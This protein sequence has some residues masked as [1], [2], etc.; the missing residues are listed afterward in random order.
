LLATL[1]AALAGT[2][3]GIALLLLAGLLP[4]ALLLTG[5]LIALLLLVLV[6]VGILVLAH[7]ISFQRWSVML[8][9]RTPNKRGANA[10]GS[11]QA[12]YDPAG[13]GWRCREFHQR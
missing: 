1:L 9:A 12:R 11:A 4:A 10:F 13:T 7:F 3:L 6:L 5:L 8:P 2:I